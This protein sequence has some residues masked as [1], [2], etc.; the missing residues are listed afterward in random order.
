MNLPSTNLESPPPQPVEKEA[1]LPVWLQ[2][3]FVVV[4]VLFCI[5]LGLTL[6]VLPWTRF[7]FYEGTLDNW[8]AIRGLL[9]HGFIRGAIS[10]L[11][12]LDIWLGVM[13]AVVY[14]DRR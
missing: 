1:E 7:W 6:I 14:R 5:E 9:H 10:G 13:E 8:P 4:Y 2:R 3:T 11:G 12:L